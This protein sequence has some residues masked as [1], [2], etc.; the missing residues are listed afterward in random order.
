MEAINFQWILSPVHSETKTAIPRF[1]SFLYFLTCSHEKTAVSRLWKKFINSIPFFQPSR[2][3]L[4]NNELTN[5]V[6]KPYSLLIYEW[7]YQFTNLHSAMRSAV[8]KRPRWI[9]SCMKLDGATWIRLKRIQ[10]EK[11]GLRISLGKLTGDKTVIGTLWNCLSHFRIEI[12]HIKDLP[13]EYYPH[14]R[15][16]EYDGRRKEREREQQMRRQNPWRDLLVFKERDNCHISKEKVLSF[17]SKNTKGSPTKLAAKF[18][19]PHS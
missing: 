19:V 16:I 5:S 2:R 8:S 3:S 6:E 4:I 10:H 17:F 13:L 18:S 15:A 9:C 7:Y 11:R 1:V 14:R 12:I